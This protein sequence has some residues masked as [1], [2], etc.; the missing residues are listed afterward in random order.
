MSYLGAGGMGTPS[1]AVK[2]IEAKLQLKSKFWEYGK[3]AIYGVRLE[4]WSLEEV[5]NQVNAV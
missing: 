4:N 3:M 1:S 2:L 5:G